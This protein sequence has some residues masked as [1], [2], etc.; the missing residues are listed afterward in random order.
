MSE[1][2]R[3]SRSKSGGNHEDNDREHESDQGS[4]QGQYGTDE[5]DGS[6][7][8]ITAHRSRCDDDDP[9]WTPANPKKLSLDT[10]RGTV[11]LP[12]FARNETVAIKQNK[13]SK[14]T[15]IKDTEAGIECDLDEALEVLSDDGDKHDG[16]SSDEL[17]DSDEDESDESDDGL[18]LDDSDS[19]GGDAVTQAKMLSRLNGDSSD[20]EEDGIEEEAFDVLISTLAVRELMPDLQAANVQEDY[21]RTI[22]DVVRWKEK[23]MSAEFRKLKQL[24]H[25]GKTKLRAQIKKVL[26]I[27]V[28]QHQIRL[29]VAAPM[30][31]E[32]LTG[33]GGEARRNV[34][35]YT[36]SMCRVKPKV[37]EKLAKKAR[38]GL[39]EEELLSD[40][41][42]EELEGFARLDG[43]QTEG[44]K[45]DSAWQ[46]LLAGVTNLLCVGET[47]TGEGKWALLANWRL[48]DDK[49]KV[50][51]SDP[52]MMKE[53]QRFRSHMN[54]HREAKKVLKEGLAEIKQLDAMP[55]E[56][57]E[58]NQ[59]MISLT[60]VYRR[61]VEGK[62]KTNKATWKRVVKILKKKDKDENAV[63]S[64][65]VGEQE[66]QPN[67]Q[68]WRNNQDRQQQQRRTQSPYRREQQV[69]FHV[70][71]EKEPEVVTQQSQEHAEHAAIVRYCDQMNKDATEVQ[72]QE[73]QA[74]GG[75]DKFGT[76]PN[77]QVPAPVG[78]A[79][80]KMFQ[81]LHAQKAAKS[82]KKREQNKYSIT[83]AREVPVMQ[84]R[85]WEQLVMEGQEHAHGGGI[86][87]QP[88]AAAQGGGV[89]HQQHQSVEGGA[90]EMEG[91]QDAALEG[92]NSTSQSMS[93]STHSDGS[94]RLG[95]RAG[96]CK[97]CERE[98][99][100]SS[101]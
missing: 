25:A 27:L 9:D 101:R 51:S 67:Q 73:V 59:L 45:L 81:V 38:S 87:Q 20:E 15:P 74:A 55:N 52:R 56:E 4:G 36:Q 90:A 13:S 17:E 100:C 28:R 54:T 72:W 10:P 43:T 57:E 97:C 21:C 86:Q 68:S 98:G 50:K 14:L 89:D 44:T 99:A 35:D 24:V 70:K 69:R 46:W 31:L 40:E 11:K 84:L 75:L 37:F 3:E 29:A 78:P 49:G 95:D 32:M 19:D 18:S 65:T 62:L 91:L 79:P 53:K 47:P 8:P 85:Q 12:T 82:R 96:L 66:T 92:N 58:V 26:K 16:G 22:S 34:L 71:D 63:F 42:F 77:F 1:A 64:W 93:S 80:K 6:P 76:N 88:A 5:H 83:R 33:T 30:L 41:S 7:L 60:K 48:L 39:V 94:P 2:D 23:S 61:F